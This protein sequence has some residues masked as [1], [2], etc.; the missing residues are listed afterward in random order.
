ML[1]SIANIN[2]NSGAE[3]SGKNLYRK[4]FSSS[5]H[6]HEDV[7]DSLNISQGYRILKEFNLNLKKFRKN[8][9]GLL[10]VQFDLSEVQFA[11][12]LDIENLT[13]LLKLD[14]DLKFA[15]T[16]PKFTASIFTKTHYSNKIDSILKI[17]NISFLLDRINSL[18]VNSEI[19]MSNTRALS[20]LM[21]GAYNG[22]LSEF[23]LINSILVTAAKNTFNFDIKHVPLNT[24]DN[25]IILI[26]KI[27]P[28]EQS[29]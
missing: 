8:N 7:H 27:T 16:I 21:D 12:L 13:N 28:I 29:D 5:I 22:I 3:N 1:K 6:R 25:E 26:Q 23:N 15:K 14:F 19:N 11:T 4:F 17:N 18:D 9:R 24:I 2:S 10:E 20:N